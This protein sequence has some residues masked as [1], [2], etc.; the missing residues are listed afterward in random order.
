[1]ICITGIPGSGKSTMS[2]RLTEMGLNSIHANEIPGY[3]ECL[4]ADEIDIECLSEK[5]SH[6]NTR[7]LIV[8]SHYS[9]LLGCDLILILERDTDHV[10]K[11]LEKRGYSE[12]KIR[13]N[14]EAAMSDVVYE[15][16][17][18]FLPTPLIRRISVEED[19]IDRT[20]ER[21]EIIIR[22]FLKRN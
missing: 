11:T 16:S 10:R 18:E 4:D 14:L 13:E 6:I 7:D 20:A 21:C 17:L 3:L 5:I 12:Q 8:E 19:D 22:D 9:H 15:E 2:Q 1:M